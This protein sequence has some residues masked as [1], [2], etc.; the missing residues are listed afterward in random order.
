MLRPLPG[1]VLEDGLESLFLILGDVGN[2]L[3]TDL[4]DPLQCSVVELHAVY[5][6]Q[7]AEHAHGHEPL[8][9]LGEILCG[10]E[11]VVGSAVFLDLLLDLGLLLLGQGRE[12]RLTQVL[13]ALGHALGVRERADHLLVG[14]DRQRPADLFEQG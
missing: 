9:V 6:P 2:V 1:G 14:I 11:E 5:S 13:D 12:H 10:I 8:T 3:I 4:F 7:L